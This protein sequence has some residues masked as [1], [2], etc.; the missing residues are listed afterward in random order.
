VVTSFEFRCQSL[1]APVFAGP[2]IF[3]LPRLAEVGKAYIDVTSSKSFPQEAWL[4]LVV[5]HGPSGQ[6]GVVVATV[7]NGSAETGAEIIKPFTDLK[8]IMQMVRHIPLPAL[9]CA[10]GASPFSG[11]HRRDWCRL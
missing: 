10:V 2:S 1:S 6:P 9:Q 5:T 8:P 11:A 7:V 4:N 3:P